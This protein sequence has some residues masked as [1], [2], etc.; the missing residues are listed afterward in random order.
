MILSLIGIVCLIIFSIPYVY[1]VCKTHS[2]KNIE[3]K[4]VC[5]SE[6]PHVDIVINTYRNRNLIIPKLEK[7][8][9]TELISKSKYFSSIPAEGTFYV[10]MNI[11]K[12]GMNAK[13]FSNYI[14]E[15]ARIKVFRGDLFGGEKY[16][17]FVRLAINLPLEKIKE[18][19]DLLESLDYRK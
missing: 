19:F 4:V 12:T 18:A 11:E 13:E 10:F 3:S 16:N 1:Y 5:K 14:Y 6:L 2:L 7:P 17:K 15:K 8:T 9:S